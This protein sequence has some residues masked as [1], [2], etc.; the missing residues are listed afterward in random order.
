MNETYIP[1]IITAAV[2]LIVAIGAQFLSHFFSQRRETKQRMNHVYQEFIYP[3]LPE[4]LLYYDTETNFRKEH[5]VEQKVD[6]EN[7]LNKISEKVSYGNTG[8][9]LHYYNIKKANH[10]FDGRGFQK[11]RNILIFMFWYLDYALDILKNRDQNESQF[12]IE[13]FILEVS[14][15]QKL[16]GIWYIFAEETEIDNATELMKFDFYIPDEFIEKL[17]LKEIKKIIKTDYTNEI[18]EKRKKFIYKFFKVMESKGDEIPIIKEIKDSHFNEPNNKQNEELKK[19]NVRSFLMN[20]FNKKDHKNNGE[21]ILNAFLIIFLTVGFILLFKGEQIETYMV[22]PDKELSE[23]QKMGLYSLFIFIIT[24]LIIQFPI[25][26]KL[27]IKGFKYMGYLIIIMLLG[28]SYFFNPLS[29]ILESY[30]KL[31]L[32]GVNLVISLGLFTFLFLFLLIVRDIMF[33]L[34]SYFRESVDI[35]AKATVSISVVAI[36]ISFIAILI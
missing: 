20:I 2:A 25:V 32:S 8:L 3:F 30:E 23:L 19:I 11:E 12:E 34:N 17:N 14:K 10:F 22:N 36:I 7:L 28:I 24:Y 29:K 1:A 5:D 31:S 35:D 21:D 13:K 26:S 27:E 9:L 18:S 16:Y 6:I 15:K 33:V 4:V